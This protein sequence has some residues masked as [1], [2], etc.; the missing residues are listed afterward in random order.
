MSSETRQENKNRQGNPLAL[1]AVFIGA[2][3]F[4]ASLTCVYLGM[5]E[6]MQTV[7]AACA[8]GGPYEIAA[9]CPDGATTLL[10]GGIF[11]MIFFG[12]L[13]FGATSWQ[14]DMSTLGVGLLMWGALFGA[15]GYNFVELSINPP[16]FM[17]NTSGWVISGVVFWLMALGGL[18]P[19]VVAIFNSLRGRDE[20]G[21]PES[22]TKFK[23]PIVRANVNFERNMPGDP[24]YGMSDASE[25]IRAQT[26]QE[27]QAPTTE[28]APM[29]HVDTAD[30]FVDPVT[31]EK[32]NP[33]G[34][35][36]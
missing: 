11:A 34:N 4:A 8:S 23:A 13:L 30:E 6:I 12:G 20:F 31:G 14:G 24:A 27:P 15:L 28:Q 35:D 1:V 7:G 19:G 3:G 25:I 17:S 2:A 26:A 32:I 5:R 22:E 36:A 18:I 33:G 29:R 10:T 9:E 16:E 21:Q